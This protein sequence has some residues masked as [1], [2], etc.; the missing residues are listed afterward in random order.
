MFQRGANRKCGSY[1]AVTSFDKNRTGNV[2]SG[3]MWD[4]G[5]AVAAAN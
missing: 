3:N 1:G 5:T 4:D 2:W